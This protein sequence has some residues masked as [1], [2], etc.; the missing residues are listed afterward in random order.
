VAA[1]HQRR[2]EHV[3]NALGDEVVFWRDASPIL[4]AAVAAARAYLT[5]AGG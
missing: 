4:A 2:V 3:T 1:E 5:G